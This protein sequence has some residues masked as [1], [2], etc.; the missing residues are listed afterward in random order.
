MF[1]NSNKYGKQQTQTQI[2]LTAHQKKLVFK[3]FYNTIESLEEYIEK[4]RYPSFKKQI[5]AKSIND[6]NRSPDELADD[7]LT[8]LFLFK[9]M[10]NK[11]PE[12]LRKEVQEEYYK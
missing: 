5:F 11:K 10:I 9:A 4:I 1:K 8:F 6:A 12:F 7:F 3:N 2:Q